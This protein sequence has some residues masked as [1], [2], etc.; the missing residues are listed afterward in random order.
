MLLLLH[1]AAD[2]TMAQPSPPFAV[3]CI[4]G[5]MRLQAMDFW[6]RNPD[7]LAWELLDQAEAGGGSFLVAEAARILSEKEEPDLRT[8][9][10]LRWRH[11]A[12]ESLDDRLS[13]LAAYGLASDIRRGEQLA[14]RRDFYL[15]SDGRSAAGNL[16]AQ[17]PDLCWYEDRAR[18]VGLVAGDAGGDELKARQK[19]VWE[20]RET[21]WTNRI[22]GI[23]PK[24]MKRLSAL[25]E[26][27]P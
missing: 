22:A 9:P 12:W 17:L 26:V 1:I 2:S 24:V 23:R 3:A 27:A 14:G 7:Y 21:R 13:L 25:T 10:M 18:L 19:Q 20:Y 15:L 6:L 4:A 11:G 5:E 16:L 8:V